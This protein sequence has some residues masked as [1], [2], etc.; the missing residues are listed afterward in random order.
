MPVKPDDQSDAAQEQAQILEKKL[1]NLYKAVLSY[2]ITILLHDPS[3]ITNEDEN[4]RTIEHNAT[5][6]RYVFM[7]EQ[8]LVTFGGAD[9]G[10]MISNSFTKRSLGTNDDLEDKTSNS[11]GEIS[12]RA[13]PE[14]TSGESSGES[15]SDDSSSE[16]DLN[17]ETIGRRLGQLHATDPLET[18]RHLDWDSKSLYNVFFEWLRAIPEYMDIVC[19]GKDVHVLWISGGPGS[20]KTLLSQAIIQG[21]PDQAPEPTHPR[22]L[23]YAFCINGP[24]GQA[25]AAGILKKLIYHI[26]DAQPVLAIHLNRMFKNTHRESFDDSADAYALSLTFYAIIQDANFASTLFLVSGIE[27][28]DSEEVDTLLN[29]VKTTLKLSSEFTKVKWILLVD[30]TKFNIES[31]SLGKD[32]FSCVDLDSRP[33]ELQDIFDR[34][35]VPAKVSELERTKLFEQDFRKRVVDL[36]SK[37]SSRNFLRAEIACEAVKREDLWHAVDVLSRLDSNEREGLGEVKS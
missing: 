26:I 2:N 34:C 24:N 36:L 1:V 11:S 23:S 4:R 13:P 14:T 7:A 37:V 16:S 19:G 32:T 33:Q 22:F 21:L 17:E 12:D 28:C 9:L 6:L 31:G 8:A 30:S 10:E 27:A 35:Y 29:I 3:T 25:N 5:Q 15:E 18:P 20:G